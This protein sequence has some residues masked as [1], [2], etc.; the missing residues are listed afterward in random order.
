MKV[1]RL[2]ILWAPSANHGQTR[3]FGRPSRD[4]NKVIHRK[5]ELP[6][7]PSQ[8]QALAARSE[9]KVPQWLQRLPH[10]GMLFP[11]DS[12]SCSHAGNC[13]PCAAR[14]PT[15]AAALF[16]AQQ[17]TLIHKLFSH[18][19]VYKSASAQSSRGAPRS[20]LHAAFQQSYPQHL[21]WQWASLWN[22]AGRAP[23]PPAFSP[24]AH[25]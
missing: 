14:R 24:T 25:A 10:P 9:G 12:A 23:A 20:L 17:R 18:R 2:P 7:F 1:L 4:I 13:G 3:A 16:A 5:S 11:I 6:V 21:S 22:H 19:A 8:N 15:T